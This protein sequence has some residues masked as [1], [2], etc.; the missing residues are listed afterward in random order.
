MT[1]DRTYDYSVA[2]FA[3]LSP[4]EQQALQ[5]VSMQLTG[6]RLDPEALEE[7]WE[8]TFYIL[9]PCDGCLPEEEIGDDLLADIRRKF[10]CIY[11]SAIEGASRRLSARNF[12]LH[13]H[14][15]F[16]LVIDPSFDDATNVAVIDRDL[17]ARP[18]C[19]L[20]EDAKAW[21]VSFP[22]L[23]DIAVEVLRIEAV[24]FSRFLALNQLAPMTEPKGGTDGQQH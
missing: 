12:R 23:R 18:Y 11:W 4:K 3:T 21:N 14:F 19:Y 2:S 20:H 6:E 22:T 24:I 9:S 1:P 15:S 8:A 16:C 7:I 13:D 17:D 5:D 10:A